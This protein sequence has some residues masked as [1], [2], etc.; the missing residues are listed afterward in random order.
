METTCY[1]ITQEAVAN[2]LRHAKASRVSLLVIRNRDHVTL[3]VEDNG[4][5]FDAGAAQRDGFHCLGLTGMK[6]RA[7]LIGGVCIIESQEGKGTVVRVQIPLQEAAP[8]PSV[9]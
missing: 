5:G 1:R 3:L 7:G 6:E 2:V 9:S 8:C 4:R